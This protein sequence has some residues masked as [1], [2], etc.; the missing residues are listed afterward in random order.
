MQQAVAIAFAVVAIANPESFQASLLTDP[1]SNSSQIVGFAWGVLIN[2]IMTPTIAGEES[3]SL[4][5]LLELS[6]P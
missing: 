1:S 2:G 3:W 5:S 6:Q 4:V